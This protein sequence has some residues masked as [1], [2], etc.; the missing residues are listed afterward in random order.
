M[1]SKQLDKFEGCR[2]ISK[3]VFLTQESSADV[4][5]EALALGSWGY[6]LK[7]KAARDLLAAVE[8]VCQGRKFVSAGLSGQYFDEC[9]DPQ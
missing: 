2:R 5:Q 1:E 7:T 4:V 6:V 8:A 3:I 9:P